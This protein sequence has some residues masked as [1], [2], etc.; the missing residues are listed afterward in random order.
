MKP[1]RH[2]LQLL[3]SRQSLV[4]AA[5]MVVVTG[6]SARAAEAVWDGQLGGNAA[7]ANFSNAVN[8]V[9]DVAPVS[10]DSL[11]FTNMGNPQN[12][13]A[14]GL[15]NASVLVYGANNDLTAG[16]SI[17]GI[18][19]DK[20]WGGNYIDGNS[21]VL[22]GDIVDNQP[23]FIQL[24]NQAFA[25]SGTRNVNVANRAA[26]VRAVGAVS[27]T[28]AGSG[29]TKTGPGAFQFFATNTFTGALTVNGGALLSGADARFGATPATPTPGAIVLNGGT[30][31]LVA[32]F[33]LNAN[34]GI[35][36][37]SNHG[38]I[39][40]P[41]A[42]TYNG[43]IAGSGNLTKTGG[44]ALT[45][46]GANTYGGSTVINQSTLNLDFGQSGAPASNIVPA[47]SPLVLN[48]LSTSFTTTFLAQ[49]TGAGSALNV[50]SGSGLSN[51]QT[52]ASVAL[53]GGQQTI[54]TASVS[55]GK[56]LLNLGAITH[57][58][59]TV[60]F[61]PAG[62]LAA[63][64]AITTTT[65]NDASGILGGWASYKGT[66]YAANDGTGKVIAYTGYT[67][68]NSGAISSLASTNVRSQTSGAFALS[69]A[70]AATTDINT[71]S[72]AN[73]TTGLKTLT[74]GAA[75]TGST[76]VLRLGAEGGV[77]LGTGAGSLVIGDVVGNGKLTAGGAADTAGAIHFI[78]HSATDSITVNSTITDNGTGA[79]A[80][81]LSNYGGLVTAPTLTLKGTN[82]Y[83]GGTV[84]YGGRATAGSTTAF[85][86]G[87]VTVRVGGQAALAAAG[88]YT[89]DFNLAGVGTGTGDF[90]SSLFLLAGTTVSGKVTLQGDA[91]ISPGTSTGSVISGQITGGY[92]L[93]ISPP[94]SG[95]GDV[96]LSNTTNNWSGNLLIDGETLKLG[97]SEVIPNGANGGSVF[98]T[99]KAASILDLNGF[100]ETING[101]ACAGSA[102]FIQ[103]NAVGTTSTLTVGDNDLSGRFE[104][105]VRDNS[106]TGGTVALVKVGTGTIVLSSSNT[107]TGGVTV[108][109]GT[110]FGSVGTGTPFGATAGTITLGDT[111]GS[112]SA[113]LRQ[114]STS[115]TAANP[116][117]VAAGSSGEKTIEAQGLGQTYTY[118]GAV[119]LNDSLSLKT[120][121]GGTNQI[122]LTGAVTGNGTVNIVAVPNG[123]AIN[124]NTNIAG[125]NTGLVMNGSSTLYLGYQNSF[126]GNV[127]VNS[128]IMQ[129]ATLA[130]NNGT[131]G[132]LGNSTLAG[133]TITVNSG[134]TLQFSINNIF[135]NGS[136]TATSLPAIILNGGTLQANRYS[137]IGRLDLNNGATLTNTSADS[138]TYQSAMF[139]NNVTVG[140]TGASTITA[141]A[142]SATQGGY[143]LSTNTTFTV[144]DATGST[145]TDLNVI[146]PLRNQSGDFGSAAGGLTKLGA[147]TMTLTGA[148]TYT[149]A[150]AVNAGTLL[151]DGSTAAGSA[152]S[153]G[154]SGTLGGTGT[155][156][157]PV[158][159]AGKIAPGDT[160]T[161][162]L[163]T[164]NATVTGTLAVQVDGAATDK[165]Q[166]SG[167]LDLTGATLNVSVLGGGFS[168]S[169]VIAE[170]TGTLTGTFASVPS[171]YAVAYN[172]G[173]GGKQ[174]ILSQSVSAYNDWATVNF[175][176]GT[177][178]GVAQDPDH[179]G[180]SNLLEFVLGGNP[181]AFSSGIAPVELLDG[182]YL[183]LHFSRSDQA[184]AETTLVVQWSTDMTNWTDIAI[185]STSSVDGMVTVT[186]GSPADTIEV[187]IPRSN[188]VNGKLFA[189]LKATR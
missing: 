163:T 39:D 134:A 93:T 91:Q 42:I 171:G 3:L 9:G 189:R 165:L 80:V 174:L 108:K 5:M 117:V 1:T 112:A 33:T 110:L 183:T 14:S 4:S 156:G 21:F 98:F 36:V 87:A 64:N 173:T 155:L 118:S 115:K 7:T 119:T 145:A 185:G 62:T 78:N 133:R 59:G 111:T 107:F 170:Y 179:D 136:V 72:I 178:N 187:K 120:Y 73:A 52:F 48:G 130:P 49:L 84:V 66:D 100:N 53:N 56:V 109:A 122:T 18:T 23:T 24:I 90:A 141:T 182:E 76:G 68:V 162:T 16:S 58:S 69:V 79:V 2:F 139:R 61:S 15:Y 105:I 147:G 116:I 6:P 89:N 161:G 148:N 31:R 37:G 126:G 45:L 159:A 20:G 30:L 65:A 140:G 103:N 67:V 82:T 166:V 94:A 8:W 26:T 97:A 169:Y 43:V 71:Y 85:G 11:R 149:G 47:T 13:G 125:A 50:A 168:G 32:A 154:A 152:V 19:F 29:F 158:T 102:P 180:I 135:G 99:S 51:T 25:I 172:A 144:A 123:G 153:V 132:S 106:G 128:G 151:V 10:G 95:S 104:G 54:S 184:A 177:N 74:V 101:I 57:T 60:N 46:G 55:S 138:N 17:S 181:L 12:A 28:V 176:D 96:T 131:T 121:T 88:T 77:M 146:A 86:T 157:G 127:V 81:R 142:I 63:D 143:H 160:G 75:G 34:R 113:T 38:T 22:T 44:A 40:T 167:N 35:S 124:L 129:A 150:T 186:D 164:G 41:S 83:S 137:T 92:T 188:A 27:E 70:D 175:L 114:N